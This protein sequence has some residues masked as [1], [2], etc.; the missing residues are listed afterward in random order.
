[1]M[2]DSL[3]D[4]VRSMS[5]VKYVERSQV[6]KAEADCDLQVGATWGIV[7]TTAWDVWPPVVYDYSYDPDT[8]GEGVDAYIIDTGI[9]LEHPD[10][11]GRAKWGFDA[12]DNP[13]P[14]TDGNGHGTHVAGTVMS[15]TYGLAKKATAIAVR[16]LNNGGSGTTEYVL[17]LMIV[18]C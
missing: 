18:C 6:Y 1:M 2:D 17:P 13:S 12:V 9:Y 8:S 4:I 10:F 5:H 11:G 16:V 14:E 3:R 15:D 7:R